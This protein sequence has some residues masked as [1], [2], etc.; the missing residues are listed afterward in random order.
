VRTAVRRGPK[1]GELRKRVELEL[2]PPAPLMSVRDV[3]GEFDGRR[4]PD[5]W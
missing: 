1:G 4:L 5:G 2:W 3:R